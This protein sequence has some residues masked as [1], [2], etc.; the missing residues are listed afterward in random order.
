M[1]VTYYP[2][3]LRS[4][5]D[6]AICGVAGGGV[7]GAMSSNHLHIDGLAAALRVFHLEGDAV[8]LGQSKNPWSAMLEPWKKISSCPLDSMKP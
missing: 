2:Y 3:S 1:V 5:S 7:G 6:Q 8:G 4:T